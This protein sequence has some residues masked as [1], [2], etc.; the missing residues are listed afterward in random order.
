MI[1]ASEAREIIETAH[2][3]KLKNFIE[4]RKTFFNQVDYL[5]RNSAENQKNHCELFVAASEL[6]YY[7]NYYREIFQQL[8]YKIS[9]HNDN[10]IIISW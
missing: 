6:R 7:E 5:I 9:F 8:G 10:K 3:L 4:E 1:S 2:S